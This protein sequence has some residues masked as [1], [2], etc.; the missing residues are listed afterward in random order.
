M[1]VEM[2]NSEGRWMAFLAKRLPE[3]L[4]DV[5]KGR[6]AHFYLASRKL[7]PAALQATIPMGFPMTHMIESIPCI[8]KYP[9]D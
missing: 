8:A 5:L 9:I 6:I 7:T 2:M 3:Q 1:V 4:D